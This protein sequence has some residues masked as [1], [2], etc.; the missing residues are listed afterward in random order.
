MLVFGC[1]NI[2]R[3]GVYYNSGF[4]VI[5]CGYRRGAVGKILYYLIVFGLFSGDSCAVC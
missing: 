1:D 4:R 2:V 5:L 3:F